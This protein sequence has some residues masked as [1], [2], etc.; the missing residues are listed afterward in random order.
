VSLNSLR[1]WRDGFG[2]SS[3]SL[4]YLIC[5]KRDVKLIAR[6]VK[7]ISIEWISMVFT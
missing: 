6:V 4:L 5:E 7:K 2:M 1:R 3:G